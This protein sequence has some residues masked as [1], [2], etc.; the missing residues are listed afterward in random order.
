MCKTTSPTILTIDLSAVAVS[1]G[2]EA[3][4]IYADLPGSKVAL[5]ETARTSFGAISD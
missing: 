4:S 5:G 1:W 3:S 2:T